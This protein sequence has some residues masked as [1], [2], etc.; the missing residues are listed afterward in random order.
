MGGLILTLK[1]ALIMKIIGSLIFTAMMLVSNIA[2]AN[3]AITVP[4]PDVM[5]LLLIGVATMG[6][7]KWKNRK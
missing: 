2:L 4:E 5:A 6:V 7:V 3:A 1:G